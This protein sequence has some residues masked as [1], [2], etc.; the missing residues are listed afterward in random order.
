M[1]NFS[2]TRPSLTDSKQWLVH[3]DVLCGQRRAHA[4]SE[5]R[6]GQSRQQPR[7]QELEVHL[8]QEGALGVLFPSN[9]ALP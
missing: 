4:H 6:C 8:L 9:G 5:L 7:E 2:K 3:P 1:K